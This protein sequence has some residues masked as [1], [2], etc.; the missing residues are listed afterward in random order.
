MNLSN[1]YTLS[2]DLSENTQKLET[3]QEDLKGIK[4]SQKVFTIATYFIYFSF[5]S[6]IFAGVTVWNLQDYIF[7][8]YTN[9]IGMTWA[10][11][12]VFAVPLALSLAKHFNYKAIAKN[13]VE[14]N[15]R[16]QVIIH[17][18]ISLALISG[19][20][21]EAISASS[22]LQAKAFH[23]V[24]TSKAGAAILNTTVGSSSTG[25][26]A[27][28]IADAEFKLVACQRKLAEGKTK[29]CDNSTAKVSSLKQQAQ[30]ERESVATA[31]VAAI[32]AK[33]AALSKERDEHA[34]PAAKYAAELVDMSNDAGTMIIVIIA[35]LFFELI[36]ITTIFNEA[37]ALR[38][39]DTYSFSL[40]GLNGEYFRATG[41]TFDSGDFKDNRTIDLSDKP[42]NVPM[43]DQ[44][45]DFEIR[46]KGTPYADNKTGFGFIPQTAKL[47]K[48][49]A[50][51][52]QAEKPGFGFIPARSNQDQDAENRRKYPQEILYPTGKGKTADDYA[53]IPRE[54]FKRTNPAVPGHTYRDELRTGS[55]DYRDMPLDATTTPP[56]EK[57]LQETTTKPLAKGSEVVEAKP[58][59][60]GSEG[61]ESLYGEWV[62]AVRI[63]EC[64]PSVEPTWHWVQKRIAPTETG[65]KTNDRTRISNM[66]KAFFSRAIREGLMQV[67]PIYR[68]GGKKYIWRGT[69]A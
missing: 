40:K 59:A 15:H 62:A 58:L 42:L 51:E 11:V 16:G 34:L 39:I 32:G 54:D 4:T 27:G 22:N 45:A 64:K 28:L 1:A 47:F 68:N 17:A 10:L 61:T 67:N 38:G 43:D 55:S 12:T 19:L 21:Y 52:V 41:K 56:A 53:L 29:D 33:Q 6:V 57:P 5:T 18:I 60:K 13:S 31:N 24:E 44:G 25:A 30:A 63:G 20:Y 7:G 8:N 35:A 46:T 69:H 37:R 50:D 36:H 2:Q 26:I 14:R 9:V 23:S 49:Q 65:S 48:W 66:Q 3:H